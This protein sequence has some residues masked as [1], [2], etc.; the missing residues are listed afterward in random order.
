MIELYFLIYRI[1]RMMSRLARERNRSALTWSLIAIG[2]WIGAELL[3]G[4]AVGIVYGIGG[5]LFGWSQDIPA[6]VTLLVYL[7]ALC[8]AIGSLTI[9]RRILLSRGAENWKPLPPP[10]PIFSND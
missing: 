4:V 8:A 9:V 2:A 5:V 10:P 6:G 7:V 1:P 3:V